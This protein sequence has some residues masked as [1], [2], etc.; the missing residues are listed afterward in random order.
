MQNCLLLQE[1]SKP[2]FGENKKNILKCHLKFLVVMGIG[3]IFIIDHRFKVN[4]QL[5]ITSGLLLL[6]L[7]SDTNGR[8]SI[9]YTYVYTFIFKI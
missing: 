3:W 7:L 9:I 6:T 2:I 1:M 4:E 5:S 8:D